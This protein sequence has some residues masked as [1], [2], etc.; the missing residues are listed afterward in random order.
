MDALALRIRDRWLIKQAVE[1]QYTKHEARTASWAPPKQ[2]VEALVEAFWQTR[3]G[4]S[5]KEAALGILRGVKRL[6]DMLKSAPGRAW[7]AISKAF[8]LPEMEGKPFTEKVKLFAARAKALAKDGQRAIK[9]LG[10]K[11][12]GT[13]PLSIYFAAKQKAPS[14]TDLMAK[15]AQKSPKVW[16]ALQKIKGG[17]QRVDKWLDKYLPTF[18]RPLLAAIFA[19]VWFNVAEISWD[20]EGLITG[21]S[22]SISF[23]ELLTSLP[24]SG[25]GFIFALMGLGYGALP[26]TIVLRVMWLVA[27]HYLMW[28]PGKGLK[29]RWEKMGVQQPDE[30]IATV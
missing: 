15:I 25:I 14:L 16:A 10:D 23:T 28:V 9:K 17:A 26:V 2:Y 13:F 8:G 24:E 20:I 27:N 12:K 11:I 7:D 6:L 19:W 29:V 3:Q 1:S 22:G 5:D 21:F 30:M 18:K 4:S